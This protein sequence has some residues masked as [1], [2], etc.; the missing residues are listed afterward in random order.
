MSQ[1]RLIQ[2]PRSAAL[3]R[4]PAR[5]SFNKGLYNIV[6]ERGITRRAVSHLC[7]TIQ[8]SL[9][10]I[11]SLTYLY[12]V[13]VDVTKRAVAQRLQLARVQ[14]G[15]NLVGSIARDS[16]TIV[17]TTATAISHQ[18]PPCTTHP[19]K[20][21]QRNSSRYS[22]QTNCLPRCIGRPSSSETPP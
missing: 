7:S 10:M 13:V 2:H 20:R 18:Y 5:S 19:R 16:R 22:R 9:C 1:N 11:I 8:F 3:L 21:T 4:P 15:N 17:V 6:I 12:A 14:R